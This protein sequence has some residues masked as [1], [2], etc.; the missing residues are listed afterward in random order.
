VSEDSRKPAVEEADRL[1]RILTRNGITPHRAYTSEEQT[2][3]FLEYK[4]DGR[5]FLVTVTEVTEAEQ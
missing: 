4:R 2:A 1:N 5:T 3:A